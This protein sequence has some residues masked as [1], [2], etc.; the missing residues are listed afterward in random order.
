MPPHL[1]GL[2]FQKKLHSLFTSSPI[3][4][5]ISCSWPRFFGG[6]FFVQNGSSKST[7]FS[8]KKGRWGRIFRC[9]NPPTAL[10]DSSSPSS[11]GRM[12]R[13]WDCS[14]EK[15]KMSGCIIYTSKKAAKKFISQHVWDGLARG[16]LV[17]VSKTGHEH[18]CRNLQ[19]LVSSTLA[20]CFNLPFFLHKTKTSKNIR[21]C[22][23][24]TSAT[25]KH[26][27]VDSTCCFHLSA[28]TETE[29]KLH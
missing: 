24:R 26:P 4:R 17:Q 16:A 9:P 20:M 23:S 11:F 3:L 18:K 10:S 28:V 8:G 15:N 6:Q 1:K 21:R 7:G 14:S 5:S 12:G 29:S 27:R 19:F 25:G 13:L 22:F 2:P